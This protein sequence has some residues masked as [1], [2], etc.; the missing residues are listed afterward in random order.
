[1]GMNDYDILKKIK[2]NRPNYNKVNISSKAK[3]FIDR[4]LT[5]D[6]KKR[7]NWVEIYSHELLSNK[8]D[9]GFIY[10]SLKSKISINQNKDFYQ[11]HVLP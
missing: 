7:I 9:A 1:M 4:C 10:G 8:N 2:N 6:P 3:D 11:K 5:L